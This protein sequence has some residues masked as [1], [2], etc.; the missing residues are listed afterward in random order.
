VILRLLLV[1]VV[2]GIAGC[3]DDAAATLGGD[4]VFVKTGGVAGINETMVVH[5]DGR[6]TVTGVRPFTLSAGELSRVADLAG[7][8]KDADVH[9]SPP[10]PDAFS[11]SVSYDGRRASTEDPSLG[12]S[13]LGPLIG[14][15][16]KIRE[17]HGP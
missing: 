13:G 3:G 7:A 16:Q 15:L 4:L 8:V 10:V 1:A 11:Y 12:E 17:A 2:L 5:P 14:E 6:A 9:E